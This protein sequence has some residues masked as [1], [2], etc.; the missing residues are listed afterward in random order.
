MQVRLSRNIFD[1][2]ISSATNHLQLHPIT[3][4]CLTHSF[5]PFG[6]W[7]IWSLSLPIFFLAT[8]SVF[9]IYYELNVVEQ[10]YNPKIRWSLEDQKLKVILSYLVSLK[11]A[12]AT[13]NPVSRKKLITNMSTYVSWSPPGSFVY[14][15]ILLEKHKV[16]Y[17]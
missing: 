4:A 16:N 13:W 15:M 7:F 10:D 12:C 5:P 17:I 9:K 2:Q 14:H 8:I 11:S 6:L 1:F 3:Y